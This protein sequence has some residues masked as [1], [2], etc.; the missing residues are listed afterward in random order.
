MRALLIEVRDVRLEHPQQVTL[1][2]HQHI[3][4][5]LMPHAFEEAFAH[6]IGIWSRDRR[7]EDLA[8]SARRNAG[9]RLAIFGGVIADEKLWPLTKKRRLPQLLGNPAVAGRVTHPNMHHPS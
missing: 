8:A 6:G 3:A 4:Q 9:K 1:A 2:E 7:L 5:A